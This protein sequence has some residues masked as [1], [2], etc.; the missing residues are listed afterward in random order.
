MSFIFLQDNYCDRKNV[1][2]FYLYADNIFVIPCKVFK[3]IL[4]FFTVL[5]MMQATVAGS[6]KTLQPVI[7][8]F[9]IHVVFACSA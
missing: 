7:Q 3:L 1:V 4:L 5:L 6:G 2:C 8:W 9:G